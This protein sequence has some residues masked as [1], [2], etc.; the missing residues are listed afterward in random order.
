MTDLTSIHFYSNL[1]LFILGIIGIYYIPGSLLLDVLGIEKKIKRPLALFVGMNLIAYMGLLLGYLQL[2]FILPIFIMLCLVLWIKRFRF[3]KVSLPKHIDPWIVAII[4]VGSFIQI[5]SVFFNGVKVGDMMFMCCGHVPDNNLFLAVVNEL[6]HRFPPYEPGMYGQNLQN[7]HYLSHLVISEFLRVTHLPLY[8]TVYQWFPFLLSIGLGVVALTWAN[9]VGLSTLYKRYLLFFLYLGADAVFLFMLLFQRGFMFQLAAMESGAVFLYNYPRAFSI[10][11]LFIALTLIHLW[12]RTYSWKL[13]IVIGLIIASLIGYKVYTGAFALSGFAILC[14][15]YF[16]KTK[17]I[18]FIVVGL[19]TLL[20]TFAIYLPVNKGAGGLFFSGMWR[21]HDFFAMKET[22]LSRWLLA[23]EI[24]V[25]HANWPRIIMLD[26]TMFVIFVWVTYGS[27]LVSLL[28]T[29]LSLKLL[30]TDQHL[31][32][33]PGFISSFIAG[34]F[35]LQ[36]TGNSSSVNFI[37]TT[38]IMI[39]IYAALSVSHMVSRVKPLLAL[40]IVILVVITTIPRPLFVLYENVQFLSR[41]RGLNMAQVSMFEYVKKYAPRDQAVLAIGFPEDY[42]SPYISF[43]TDRP[44][45]LSGVG[46]SLVTHGI[47]YQDREKI[48]QDIIKNPDVQ[49]VYSLL[50]QQQISTIVWNKDVPFPFGEISHSYSQKEDFDVYA[51][52]SVL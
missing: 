14:G 1:L 25:A 51:V 33:I 22:G 31:V 13:G 7:Y 3:E 15:W 16:L 39:S 4:V 20:V 52:I 28:Q 47:P 27:K 19:V 24:F 42:D 8:A 40:G 38:I 30:S 46:N 35:F 50:Q 5:V 29:R 36:H 10:L 48:V 21:V 34:M 43:M 26:V 2:R 45:Y 9:V 11:F 32:L 41:K 44:S 23:R 18:Q 12:V 17:R 49:T 37:I 6:K